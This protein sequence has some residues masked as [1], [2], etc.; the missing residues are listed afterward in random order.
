MFTCLMKKEDKSESIGVHERFVNGNWRHRTYEAL[1]K[2][3]DLAG[4]RPGKDTSKRETNGMAHPRNPCQHG[5]RGVATG[6]NMAK[7]VGAATQ[8]RDHKAFLLEC[9]REQ[10]RRSGH[11]G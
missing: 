7:T 9:R 3:V 8:G 5:R 2:K 11:I 4:W 1:R 10:V 6:G